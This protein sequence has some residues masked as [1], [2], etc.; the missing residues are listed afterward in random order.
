[1]KI[2]PPTGNG[3]IH[4]YGHYIPKFTAEKHPE[5]TTYHGFKENRQKVAATFLK[6]TT[7]IEYCTIVTTKDVCASGN[8]TTATRL[9]SEEEE[10]LYHDWR[11]GY[12]GHFRATNDTSCIDNS[13]CF[14]HYIKIECEN[15]AAHSD[16]QMYWNGIPLQSVGPYTNGGYDASQILD[17]WQ[18]AS[19]TQSNVLVSWEAP[20]I[21]ASVF[22]NTNHAFYRVKFPE[23]TKGCRDFHLNNTLDQCSSN[24]TQRVGQNPL[25]ACDSP[26]EEYFTVVSAALKAQYDSVSIEQKPPALEFV[27]AFTLKARSMQDMYDHNLEL[28]YLTNGEIEGYSTRETVCR[29]VYDNLESIETAVPNGYPR[30]FVKV[31]SQALFITSITFALAA[32]VMTV[33]AMILAVL[34][35]KH[36]VIRQAQITF[37]AWF[38]A[39][40]SVAHLCASMCLGDCV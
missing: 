19:E 8:D 15:D 17:I 2:L 20:S 5:Y 38:L 27:E 14:G 7:W 23:P 26:V 1:M 31:S 25:V 37:L 36:I 35:R 32:L 30:I 3:R 11:G 24:Y 33:S 12:K 39:G 10:H 4:R 18:A 9:P 13:A 40:E 16:A 28:M 21:F 6:P 29:W 34:Y 22:A